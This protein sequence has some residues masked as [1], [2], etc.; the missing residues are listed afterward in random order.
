MYHPHPSDLLNKIFSAKPF[1]G[2]DP[3][4]ATFLFVGLDANYAPSIETTPIFSSIVDYLDDG[5]AFWCKY[6]VHHPFLLPGYRGD[7]RLYHKTFASIGF[8]VEHAAQV[9]FV[10]LL[11][12]PTC[13]RSSLVPEDL[14]PQHLLRFGLFGVG[15]R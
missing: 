7:G 9:S 12:V 6:G 1:Q 4:T 15:P 2:A 13:G 8:T 10:E 11:H 3:E 14:D 5:V